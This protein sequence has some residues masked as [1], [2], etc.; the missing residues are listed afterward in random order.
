MIELT[1]FEKGYIAGLIVGEGSFTGDTKRNGY[2]M[3]SIVVKMNDDDTEPTRFLFEKLGGKY[4]GPYIYGIRHFCQWCIRGKAALDLIPIMLE[5]IPES[6][7]RRQLYEWIEKTNHKET[8]RTIP[9]RSP[10]QLQRLQELKE[11]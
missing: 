8:G 7:K 4:Y 2:F 3:P 1:D 5:I 10:S 6:R 11:T 9:S